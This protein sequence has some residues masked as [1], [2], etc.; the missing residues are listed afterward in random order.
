MGIEV[1]P[2]PT[3]NEAL[4]AVSGWQVDAAIIDA[5]SARQLMIKSYPQLQLN[6]YVTHDPLAIA[7]WGEST[8]L[9]AAINRALAEM[10]QDGTTARIIESWLA[11]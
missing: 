4:Q 7:V 9:L 8:Q 3:A 5:V 1:W 11:K 6:D 10:Q 2:F